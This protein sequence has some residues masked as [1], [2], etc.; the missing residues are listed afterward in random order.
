MQ[1]IPLYQIDAF[2]DVA[3]QGN[4]AAI[5]PLTEFLPDE[6]LQ[7]IA[8]E[9][10]LAETAYYTPLDG[11]EAD[12]HLRW[13]TP[14]TEVKL[15]G[16]ATLAAAYVIFR[17]FRHDMSKLRFLT[18]SGILTVEKKNGKLELCFP[19]LR[20]APITL[21]VG[22]AAAMGAEPQEVYKGDDGDRD[23]LLIYDSPEVILG[24]EPDLFALKA[25]APYGFIATAK[26]LGNVDF[27]S[28]CF[29]PNHGIN[30]DPVTGSAHCMSGPFWAKRLAKQELYARQISKRGGDLWLRVPGDGKVYIAGQAIEVLRGTFF[31]H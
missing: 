10:N 15:C 8:A 21:P 31:L 4:P 2:T 28:R 27:V 7:T 3:F 5:C 14:E 19:E 26:G 22:L 11:I 18:L 29:F 24:L 16:H 17:H 13:F 6:S 30:E 12:Y 9:N 25:F 1:E 20:A 23:L